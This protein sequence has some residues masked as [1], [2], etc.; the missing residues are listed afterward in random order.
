ML[1]TLRGIFLFRQ[2]LTITLNRFRS[3]E[4]FPAG[5]H[6]H[7]WAF[8]A[9]P[10]ASSDTDWIVGSKQLRCNYEKAHHKQYRPE[11]NRRK[12][13]SCVT[14]IAAEVVQIHREPSQQITTKLQ[15][16]A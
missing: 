11:V 12:I 5:E 14:P 10:K 9:I 6:N 3:H 7:F 13:R 8:R 1:G 15:H 4:K 2:G 16:K